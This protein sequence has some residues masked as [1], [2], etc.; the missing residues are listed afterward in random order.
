MSDDHAYQA[1]SA[2][3]SQINET[4]HIDRLAREGIRFGGVT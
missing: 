3:G 2:Y 4:P 1:I